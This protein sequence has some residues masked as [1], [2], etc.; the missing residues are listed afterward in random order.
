MKVTH[1]EAGYSKKRAVYWK[2]VGIQDHEEWEISCMIGCTQLQS[3][4][5]HLLPVVN[6]I[7]AIIG[8]GN[9]Y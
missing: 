5:S 1:E 8:M 4:P 7:T 9:L 3:N 2:Q 6:D